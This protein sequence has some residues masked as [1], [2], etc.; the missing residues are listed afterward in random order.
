MSKIVVK[1]KD[2]LAGVTSKWLMATEG[3]ESIFLIAEDNPLVSK[4]DTS[5]WSPVTF[6]ASTTEVTEALSEYNLDV[7][8]LFN[9]TYTDARVVFNPDQER[10][11]PAGEGPEDFFSGAEV[12]LDDDSNLAGPD[13][14]ILIRDETDLVHLPED[15]VK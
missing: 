14:Y 2:V 6:Y 11:L 7:Q 5:A 3:R 1:G 8:I 12:D 13:A 10:A 9:D 15:V 4:I